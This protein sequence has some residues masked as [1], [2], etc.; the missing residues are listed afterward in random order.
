M[1]RPQKIKDEHILAVARAVFLEKG[2]LATTAEVAKRAGVAE[3]S[4]FHRFKTKVA[5]FQAA[6]HLGK[7]LPA[8][9]RNLDEATQAAERSLEEILV[10]GG[11]EAVE[12]FRSL[13]PL[14]MMTWSNPDPNALPTPLRGPNPLP[15]RGLK[16]VAAVFEREM[17]AGRMRRHDPEIVARAYLGGIVHYVFLEIVLKAQDELPLPATTFVRG[18]VQLLFTGITPAPAPQKK[19]SGR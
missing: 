8:F 13:M 16:H 5:L 4:I 9:L 11:L 14:M 18:L 6:M 17:R 2:I 3:G 15:L 1:S 12:F 10:D 7:E 19:R